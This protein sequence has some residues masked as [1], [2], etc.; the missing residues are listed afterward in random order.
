MSSDWFDSFD[1]T[2]TLLYR[3]SRAAWLRHHHR[4]IPR[5]LLPDSQDNQHS[6]AH[7]PRRAWRCSW[8][9][10]ARVGKE[11]RTYIRRAWVR[12]DAVITLCA[13]VHASSN[14]RTA[15][16]GVAQYY[17]LSLSM[18]LWQWFVIIK[19]I[20]NIGMNEK[21]CSLIASFTGN[22]RFAMDL[23]ARFLMNFGTAVLGSLK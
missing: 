10:S 13:Q 2:F 21:S 22:R 4:D 14:R 15:W 16:C 20:L 6:H 12:E 3:T 11:I 23:Y 9:S 19:Q 7:P 5:L 18:L 17:P 1:F 8:Q